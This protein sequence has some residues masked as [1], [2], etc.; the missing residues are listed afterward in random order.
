MKIYVII[1]EITGCHTISSKDKYRYDKTLDVQK[2]RKQQNEHYTQNNEQQI[3]ETF[4][5]YS[6]IFQAC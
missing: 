4:K 6:A 1:R 2:Q 3:K 5:Y